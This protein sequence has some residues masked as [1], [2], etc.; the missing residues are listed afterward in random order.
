MLQRKEDAACGLCS[1][2]PLSHGFC[3]L[4]ELGK[5]RPNAQPRFSV[6]VL[7]LRRSVAAQKH[8][9]R[10]V[11]SMPLDRYANQKDGHGKSKCR[12]FASDNVYA[13]EI[14]RLRVA[15]FCCGCEEMHLKS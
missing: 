10:R 5:V 6:T 1:R 2:F 7:L 13:D 8:R 11:A 3:A 15:L 4:G 14:F 9:N 12:M